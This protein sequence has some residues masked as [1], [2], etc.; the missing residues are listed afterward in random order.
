MARQIAQRT[1]LLKK[2]G[3]KQKKLVSRKAYLTLGTKREQSPSAIK[4]KTIS[5]ALRSRHSQKKKTTS[6]VRRSFNP[7]NESPILDLIHETGY[8]F[9]KKRSSIGHTQK[10]E[11][12]VTCIKN[13]PLNT[14]LLTSFSKQVRPEKK[15]LGSNGSRRGGLKTPADRNF[16]L[17]D[18]T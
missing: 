3:R 15:R 5:Q 11:S 7:A 4:Q 8:S 16:L 1:K 14:K 17:N 13:L 18:Q 2:E 9:G 6:K 10:V 12:S